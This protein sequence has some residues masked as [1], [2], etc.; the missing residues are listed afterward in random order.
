MHNEVIDEM[1]DCEVIAQEI[2]MD[3]MVGTEATDQ[4]DP[5]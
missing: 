4:I 2:V 1:V 3:E 5:T